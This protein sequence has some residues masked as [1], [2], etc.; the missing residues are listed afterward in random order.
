MTHTE[1]SL[2]LNNCWSPKSKK[3]IKVTIRLPNLL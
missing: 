3:D 1:T 2:V